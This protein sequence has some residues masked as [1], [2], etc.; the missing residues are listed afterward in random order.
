MFCLSEVD[1][2][3]G[4]ETKSALLKQAKPMLLVEL[5]ELSEVS[6]PNLVKLTEQEW[7][8]SLEVLRNANG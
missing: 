5:L 1:T 7:L 4:L 8:E 2:L 6:Q 3:L